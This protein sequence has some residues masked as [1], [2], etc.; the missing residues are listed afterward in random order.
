MKKLAYLLTALAALSMTAC[1]G[2]M[3]GNTSDVDSDTILTEEDLIV[4]G[5]EGAPGL[6]GD[7][8]FVGNS[9]GVVVHR[10]VA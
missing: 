2:M 9:A 4:A 10:A 3:G 8:T 6:I 1:G 7:S 5:D